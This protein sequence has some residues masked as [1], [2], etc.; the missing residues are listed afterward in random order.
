MNNRTVVRFDLVQQ[1]TRFTIVY[2]NQQRLLMLDSVSPNN[3]IELYIMQVPCKLDMSVFAR[4][5]HKFKVTIICSLGEEPV[6]ITKEASRDK[7]Q[8]RFLKN[9][10]TKNEDLLK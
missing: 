2:L 9:M 4:D 5:G 1:Q 3:C 6:K 10:Q 8:M 7:F